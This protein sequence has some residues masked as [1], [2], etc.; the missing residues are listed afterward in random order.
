MDELHQLETWAAPFLAKLSSA[1][2]RGLAR[3]IGT[4]LRRSQAQRIKDQLNPDGSAYAPRKRDQAGEIK[5]RKERMF[6]RITQ[7]RHLRVEASDQAVAVG[8]MG[9]VARI[10]MVHQEGQA[11]RVTRKGSSVRYERRQ[12]L[13][14]S[15]AERSTIRDLIVE[16]LAQ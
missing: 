2:R 7:A 5:R 6:Q 3:R 1:E 11:D 4:T 12:L 14:F 13:G 15:D 8:F 10:A 16:H 9:R